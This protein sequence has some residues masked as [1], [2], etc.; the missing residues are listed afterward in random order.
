M[1]AWIITLVNDQL[2]VMEDE[3]TYDESAVDRIADELRSMAKPSE[4]V[5]IGHVVLDLP[6]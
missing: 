5:A 2:E 4:H 6:F 1:D 3:I